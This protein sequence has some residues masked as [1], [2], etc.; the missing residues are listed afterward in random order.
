M[1]VKRKIPLAL[2]Q[3]ALASALATV[4]GHAGAVLVA[5]GKLGDGAVGSAHGTAAA[6]L[7]EGYSTG[8]VVGF[9]DDKGHFIGNGQLWFGTGADG[10]QFLYFMMPTDYVDNT[11]GTNASTSGHTLN[12]LLGDSLG[13]NVNFQWNDKA[14]NY[15]GAGTTSSGQI[16]YLADCS[17]STTAAANC[18]NKYRSAGIGNTGTGVVEFANGGSSKWSNT[19]NSL[20]GSAASMLQVATSLEYDLNMIDPT[21][22]TNSSLNANWLK[23]V[24]YELQFKAGTFDPTK[25][26]QDV[27][28]VNGQVTIPGLLTLGDPHVSPPKAT[29][30]A[31]A[32]PC[33]I[34]SSGC[35]VP[36]PG[37]TWLLGAGL[38]G[39]AWY[40][41]RRRQGMSPVRD[42]ALPS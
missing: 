9:N 40:A 13:A 3:L 30:G 42:Q 14:G 24:G 20:S 28:L 23:E 35:G 38:V 31:F 8:W 15:A 36:E 33:L 25:W 21:A 18:P 26:G 41:R 27:Q 5:D 17:G 19:D 1:S 34:G 4:Y 11:Y 12:D 2:R 6:A 7:T 10:S 29:F 16:D 22:T 37:T 32:S 39:M